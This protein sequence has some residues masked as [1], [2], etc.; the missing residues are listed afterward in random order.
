MLLQRGSSL[1]SFKRPSA[2]P[3]V[4]VRAVAEPTT[5]HSNG[6]GAAKKDKPFINV[7]ESTAWE[8]GIPPVMVGARAAGALDGA[9]RRPMTAWRRPS[10]C[11][12][13]PRR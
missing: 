13:M 5:K 11:R 1:L 6:N 8:K 12:P 4:A 7:I 10:S 2:A 9:A 3:S